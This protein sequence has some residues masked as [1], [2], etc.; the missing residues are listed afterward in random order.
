MRRKIIMKLGNRLKTAY[1][2]GVNLHEIARKM[3]IPQ[4]LSKRFN[5]LLLHGYARLLLF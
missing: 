1:A 5:L 3:N 4:V 2:A